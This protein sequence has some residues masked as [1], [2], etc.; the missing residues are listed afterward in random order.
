MHW[1]DKSSRTHLSRGGYRLPDRRLR[2]LPLPPGAMRRP[3]DPVAQARVEEAVPLAYRLAWRMHRQH[4]RDVPVDELIAEA[5]YALTYAAAMFDEARQVPFEPY[6]VL[7]IRH[8][9]AHFVRSWRHNAWQ[10]GQ[11]PEQVSADD[12]PWEAADD[13]PAPHPVTGLVAREMCDRVR[14]GAS[15]AAAGVV[16]GP[17]AVPRRGTDVPGDRAEVRGDPAAHPAGA[18]PGGRAGPAAVP[19]MGRAGGRGVEGVTVSGR[20]GEREN[21]PA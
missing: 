3:L 10:A 13:N 16:H 12:A 7:T 17:A 2:S 21:R 5:L 6:A 4:A 19:G 1:T 8:R 11:Y 14:R 18:G 9:L 15:G 20:G